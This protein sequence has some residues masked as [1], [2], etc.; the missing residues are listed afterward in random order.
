MVSSKLIR[1]GGL[2]PS[3]S[4]DE[5][6]RSTVYEALSNTDESEKSHQTSGNLLP[7]AH[8]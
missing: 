3:K 5:L 8:V 1:L 6:Q 2:G 4:L 7:Q